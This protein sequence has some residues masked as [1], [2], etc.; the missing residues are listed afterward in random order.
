MISQLGREGLQI[1]NIDTA[2]VAPENFLDFF[3][4]VLITNG[5]PEVG[6]MNASQ[7]KDGNHR[8][9]SKDLVVPATED[10]PLVVLRYT[11]DPGGYYGNG[12]LK[13]SHAVMTP[14]EK[15]GEFQDLLRFDYDREYLR[16][17]HSDERRRFRRKI[18]QFITTPTPDW[19]N[20]RSRVLEPED[21]AW[22]GG[23]VT[24]FLDRVS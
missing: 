20:S 10:K 21:M 5:I 22:L 24:D 12:P 19:E 23:I 7:V 11:Y 4:G 6:R 18:E 2:E 8:S 15:V 16:V 14:P 3:R 17:F 9:V 1:P 13:E